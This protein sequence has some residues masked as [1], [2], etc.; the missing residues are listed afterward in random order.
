MMGFVWDLHPRPH[1]LSPGSFGKNPL[2]QSAGYKGPAP[3]RLTCR[4]PHHLSF[5]RSYHAH[6]LPLLH[7][8][9]PHLGG[10]SESLPQPYLCFPACFPSA[11]TASN[12]APSVTLAWFHVSNRSL[13]SA[14]KRHLLKEA[15]P[16]APLHLPTHSSPRHCRGAFCERP[17]AL[18]SAVTA[19]TRWLPAC[20]SL[21]H[22]LRPWY[23]AQ[24]WRHGQAQCWGLWL[25]RPGS[26]VC[27]GVCRWS[28]IFRKGQALWHHMIIIKT[29][30]ILTTSYWAP[31][32]VQRPKVLGQYLCKSVKDWKLLRIPL[33]VN[34]NAW[35]TFLS[36]FPRVTL[37]TTPHPPRTPPFRG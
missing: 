24:P 1:H 6:P 8:L 31:V 13:A 17:R 28:W 11:F 22:I 19:F 20:P 36:V 32:L 34:S 7:G 16:I 9:P 10:S 29:T 15:L 27:L 18:V 3:A 33:G 35:K 37:C 25:L 4:A 30:T 5:C 2:P 14:T 23:A 21:P 12:F 26:S